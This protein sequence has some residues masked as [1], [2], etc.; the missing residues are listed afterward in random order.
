MTV[1][2]AL[3]E[4][5]KTIKE[6]FKSSIATEHTLRTPFENLLNA[7]K[8]KEIKVV[9]EAVKEEFENGTPDFKIFKQIDSAEKLTYPNLVG[10]IECKKL[11]ENLDKIIKTPQIKKYLEVSPNILVTD[12]NR[13]ID[14]KRS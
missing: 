1:L 13:F 12:Y 11:N 4:Y 10:Y 14:S 5:G 7:I 8:P 6:N 2:E 3:E 9:H